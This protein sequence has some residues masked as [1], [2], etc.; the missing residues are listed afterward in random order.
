MMEL[1]K[2][3]CGLFAV[4][5]TVIGVAHASSMVHTPLGFIFFIMG[6][7]GFKVIGEFLVEA[8]KESY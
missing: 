5:M 2:A 3:A 4:L 7:Y 6:L 8:G 1:I